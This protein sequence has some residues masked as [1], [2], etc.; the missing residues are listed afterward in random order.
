MNIP[1]HHICQACAEEH[2][3]CAKCHLTPEE[4]DAKA[5]DAIRRGQ[6][7]DEDAEY[8]AQLEAN[9]S[10]EDGEKEEEEKDEEQIEA[11][12]V[13]KEKLEALEAE[14]PELLRLKGLDIS[15]IRYN[16]EQKKR[17]GAYS[18]ISQ[19]GK[20]KERER[21]S[22]LRKLQRGDEKGALEIAHK[23]IAMREGEGMNDDDDEQ[24]SSSDDEN[25][26]DIKEVPVK[27]M[28]KDSEI[29]LNKMSSSKANAGATASSSKPVLRLAKAKEHAADDTPS[30]EETL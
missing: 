23:A 28:T 26:E 20:L 5:M 11:E 24:D 6:I 9:S 14:H 7:Q 1:F 22:A 29:D 17:D 19:Q 4:S 18:L 21:R 16:L 2:A 25:D 13:E 12:R 30:D 3:V 10:D 27:Q 15:L 8:F